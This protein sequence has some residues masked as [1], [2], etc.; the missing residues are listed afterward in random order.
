MDKSFA[1]VLILLLVFINIER[2]KCELQADTASSS[3][4]L[5]LKAY[6]ELD[7]VEFKFQT[8]INADLNLR[9]KRQTHSSSL[10]SPIL[11]TNRLVFTAFN[12]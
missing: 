8:A 12:R 6:E 2:N 3:N 10:E 1:Q 11:D 7:Y 5:P 9:K 4:R